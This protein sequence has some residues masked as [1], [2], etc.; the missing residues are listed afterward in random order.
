MKYAVK[1]FITFWVYKNCSK[2]N[3]V[4]SL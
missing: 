2:W 4:Y 3:P 1:A